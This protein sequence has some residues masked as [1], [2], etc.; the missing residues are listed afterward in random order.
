M[1]R[2][3]VR[4][5]QSGGCD[6]TIECGTDFTLL[7]EEIQT[8]EQAIAKVKEMGTPDNEDGDFLDDDLSI[9]EVVIYEIVATHEF[10]LND[11]YAN[12]EKHKR[13]VEAAQKEKDDLVQ[14]EKLKK[15]YPHAAHP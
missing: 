11:W 2:F 6:Y 15:Q 7:P 8:M 10:D 9:S 1:S 13:E 3:A 12:K 5:H 4:R 14:L